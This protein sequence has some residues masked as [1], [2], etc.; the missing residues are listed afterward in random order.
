MTALH[1]TQPHV[2]VI[3]KRRDIVVKNHVHVATRTLPITREALLDSLRSAPR[4]TAAANIL[5]HQAAELDLRACVD[6]EEAPPLIWEFD[7]LQNNGLLFDVEPEVYAD[8]VDSQEQPLTA[9]ILKPMDGPDVRVHAN[10]EPIFVY[11]DLVVRCSE[12]LD[13]AQVFVPAHAT[14]TV[15]A[16]LVVT[17]SDELPEDWAEECDDDSDEG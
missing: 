11:W 6:R 8:D 14:F 13:L 2:V 16:R 9:L 1:K 5:R 17:R 7:P 3:S 10:G 15:E 12:G 4:R